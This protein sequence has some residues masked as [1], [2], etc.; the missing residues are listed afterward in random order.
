MPTFGHSHEWLAW[1]ETLH[2]AVMELGLDRVGSVA[3]RMGLAAKLPFPVIS[4]AGTNGKGSTVAMLEAIYRAAG[5]RTGAYTSPHIYRFNERIRLD[6]GDIHEAALLAALQRVEAAR[7]GVTLTWFEYTTLA[8]IA[9]M[10]TAE[11]EVGLLEVGLGGRL[12]AVNL[13]DADCALLTT[14]D[15]DH[16]AWLGETREA[17]GREKAGIFRADAPAICAERDLPASVVEQARCSG[18]HLYRI[19]H[20]FDV[21]LP[22]GEGWLWQG[23]AGERLELPLPALAGR[24]QLDNAAGAVAAVQALGGCLPVDHQALA[25]GMTRVHL[26]GRFQRLS[27]RPELVVDVAHNRQSARALAEMLHQHPVNGRTWAVFAALADKEIEAVAASLGAAVDGWFVAGLSVPRGQ[28]GAETAERLRH[29]LPADARVEVAES[30]ALALQ[31][32]RAVAS[33]DDRIVV[34]GSF[35]T[36]AAIESETYNGKNEPG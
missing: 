35:H 4:V 3:R 17:I 27:E 10:I 8:A 23:R 30:V 16:Q 29:G 31:R 12:D 21:V 28:G 5:Y 6:G 26:P 2:P 34:F 13:F 14:V 22:C 20:D 25:A 36:L 33:V 1:L 7:D 9:A 11:V 24:F 15:L 32:A 18:A 19:G